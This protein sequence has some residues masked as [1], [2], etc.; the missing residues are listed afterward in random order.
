MFVVLTGGVLAGG[1]VVGV[2]G[3][4]VAVGPEVIVSVGVPDAAGAL[5]RKISPEVSLVT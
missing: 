2:V 4:G 1:V 3:V 5:T